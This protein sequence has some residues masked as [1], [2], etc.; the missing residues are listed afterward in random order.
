M[1]LGLSEDDYV[2]WF[3]VY[4][5]PE[6]IESSTILHVWMELQFCLIIT[7]KITDRFPFRE[8]ID[9]YDVHLGVKKKNEELKC[10]E[11]LYKKQNYFIEEE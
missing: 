9:E 4:N 8:H 1:Y 5:L 11:G 2:H 3:Q 10:Q 6:G 7:V